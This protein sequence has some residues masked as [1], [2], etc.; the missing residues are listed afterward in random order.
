LLDPVDGSNHDRFRQ[1]LRVANLATVLTSVAG[2]FAINIQ[3]DYTSTLMPAGLRTFLTALQPVFAILFQLYFSLIFT[4]AIKKHLDKNREMFTRSEFSTT[5]GSVIR[6]IDTTASQS[7]AKLALQ[8][9]LVRKQV[10]LQVDITLLIMTH[11]LF[12]IGLLNQ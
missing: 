8:N 11:F 2:H 6:T 9:S 5:V 12:L 3:R 7:D 1:I 10:R 4:K